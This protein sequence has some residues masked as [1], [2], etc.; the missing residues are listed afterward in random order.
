MRKII[1]F[2]LIFA[3][4]L[5][6]ASC[7]NRSDDTPANTTT[8]PAADN[9]INVI[10][11]G[12]T[13]YSIVY[14][15]IC[16][17]YARAA[18]SKLSNRIFEATGVRIFALDDKNKESEYEIVIGKTSREGV[19]AD[20]YGEGYAWKEDELRVALVGKKIF[21]SAEDE[22][23]LFDNISYLA[24]AWLTA[25]ADGKLAIN[26]D[27]CA[28]LNGVAE[29]DANTISILSHNILNSNIIARKERVYKEI[30]Y[31]SPDIFA[32]QEGAP[33]WISYLDQEL[34][35]TGYARIEIA[36]EDS[37]YNSIYYRADRFKLIES[38]TFWLS[39]TPDVPN[40]KFE[41][42]H[43][44]HIATWGL[45]EIKA[46]G[47]RFVYLNTHLD[48]AGDAVTTKEL[49]L[50]VDFLSKYTDQYPVYISG[51]FNSN[52]YS[53]AYKLVNATYDD[54]RIVAKN[55]LTSKNQVTTTP[56]ISSQNVI[57]YVFT[58]KNGKQETL[59]YKV[60]I[61]KQ[62][63]SYVPEGYI[64]DHYALFVRSKIL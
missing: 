13:D 56:Q 29:K 32:L 36:P 39:A 17:G 60:V 21:I 31:F 37:A 3:T 24:D 5:S 61:E 62:F 46:T 58:A 7:A 38:D 42:A 1:V 30:E 55:K 15:I 45:F 49:G 41:G 44:T 48:T 12:K 43:Y 57:D 4:L 64:S 10:A 18:A 20:F 14:P 50:I 35:K 6:L 23:E 63:G 27:M 34:G 16:E 53:E 8:T 9:A 47:K 28:Q 26:E 54:S 52:P 40:T 51:D 33:A 11:D 22:F 59:A 19:S 25:Y 2:V